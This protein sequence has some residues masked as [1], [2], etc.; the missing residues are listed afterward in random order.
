MF[1]KLGIPDKYK[2]VAI[3]VIVVVFLVLVILLIKAVDRYKHNS[4][5]SKL[6]SDAST[7][8]L[9][10]LTYPQSSYNDAVQGLKWAFQVGSILPR[11]MVATDSKMV[12]DVLG[13]MRTYEDMLYLIKLFGI[14]EGKMLNEWVVDELS[15][16]E[17]KTL[18][19]SLIMNKIN[20]KFSK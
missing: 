19:N 18:N 11:F 10:K 7:A 1:E 9:S 3:L 6:S 15:D 2:G 20:Y 16:V 8:D 4:D 13:K 17:I 5:N 14:Q 12:L